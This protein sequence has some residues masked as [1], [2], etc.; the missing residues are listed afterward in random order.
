MD[1][2]LRRV[3]DSPRALQR[4]H[5]Q[6]FAYQILRALKYVHSADIIH[7]DLKPQN[8][9][10][11]A[12]CDVKLADFGG[13]RQRRAGRL[14]TGGGGGGGG[15][16]GGGG[17]SDGDDGDG[18]AQQRSAQDVLR[19]T[20][21]E[22][23]TTRYYRAP[24]GVLRARHYSTAVDVWSV[25]C[26]LAEL[27]ARH[28]LFPSAADRVQQ[29]QCV[30]E[31][32]GPPPASLCASDGDDD[33]RVAVEH[34]AAGRRPPPTASMNLGGSLGASL[35]GGDDD[36][37]SDGGGGAGAAGDG[38]R[39][40]SGAERRQRLVRRLMS[41]DEEVLDL[42]T[43]MLCWQ[44]AER[45][46]V[47]AALAHDYFEP[48]HDPADEPTLDV[49]AARA[50]RALLDEAD[51]AADRRQLLALLYADARGG[52]GGGGGGGAAT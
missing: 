3:I 2:D 19:M 43:Q 46:S 44:P 30:A 12:N 28:P 42:L 8:V 10:V 35:G 45:I 14:A 33:L 49:R 52:G 6:T 21:L 18:D 16:D 36:D 27:V 5:V 48:L 9:L 23:V 38:A 7:R 34:L 47:E 41:S 25:G 4:E 15:G 40:L 50:L 51:A 13:G 22:T 37:G 31:L 24:E 20:L 39:Q 1:T 11:N 17:D 29:L 32:L 26:I